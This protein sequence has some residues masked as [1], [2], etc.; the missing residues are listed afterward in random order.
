M[1][2]DPSVT[3]DPE[4]S[5]RAGLKWAAMGGAIAGAAMFSPDQAEAAGTSPS[6]VVDALGGGDY[7]NIEQAIAAAPA[8]CTV[9]VKRGTYVVTTGNMSRARAT[10]P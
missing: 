6:I 9:F 7:T 8:G 4:F 5:R 10:G 2:D 3:R 1:S